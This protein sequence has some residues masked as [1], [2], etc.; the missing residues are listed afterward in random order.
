M[1][2]TINSDLSEEEV[3]TAKKVLETLESA[4]LNEKFSPEIL[5]HQVEVVDCMLEQIQH[6]ENNMSKLD[7]QDFRLLAHRMELERIRF[8][9]SSYLR[10]RLEKIELYT[11]YILK[12][13]SER[14]PDEQRLSP[15]ELIF[16]KEFLANQEN[17]LNQVALRHMPPNFQTTDPALTMVKP[18]MQTHVFLQAKKSLAAI[19]VPF[20]DDEV[21]LTEGS[22]HVMQYEPIAEMVCSG[23]VQLI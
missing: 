19:V 23:A 13:E 14:T 2:D 21:D 7:K 15:N 22:Q 12:Q 11:Q 3:V 8:I 20:S 5:P 10:L 16:A 1:D 9:I 18:N 4:W 17:H 6:M